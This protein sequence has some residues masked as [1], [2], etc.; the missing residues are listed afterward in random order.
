M[1][2]SHSR[3][4]S[5]G[6]FLWILVLAGVDEPVAAQKEAANGVVKI[7]A[8]ELGDDPQ[9]EGTGFVVAFESGL[10]F[11]ATAA[12]VVEGDPR[13]RVIFSAAPHQIYESTPVRLAD[14]SD[15][16]VLKIIGF[17]PKT[18]V[19]PFDE[20]PV[21]P[22]DP[23]QAIGFPR[24]AL[25]PRWSTMAAS[26]TEGGKIVLD[27]E[28]TEGHSGGPLL[29]GGY[30]VGMVNTTERSYS[31]ALPTAFLGDVLG[32]WKI[33]IKKK[34]TQ[35]YVIAYEPPPAP[36]TSALGTL[37]MSQVTPRES[38]CVGMIKSL[39]GANQ[40]VRIAAVTNAM[41]L[42]Y[43][44]VDTRVVVVESFPSSAPKWYRVSF[45]SMEG[46]IEGDQLELSQG[47]TR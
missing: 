13:P 37:P 24:R 19:L 5:L 16:A 44:P 12:H 14:D 20:R 29:R 23:L 45:E 47:C 9:R 7:L 6:L 26:S 39:T 41:V 38:G 40:P 28:L 25:Q 10:T 32:S 2:N 30:V 21:E 46:W 34:R 22:A 36:T 43:L 18:I 15:V 42:R 33:P 3:F 35:K 11:I 8:S 1:G 31:F 4:K 27:E 17:V